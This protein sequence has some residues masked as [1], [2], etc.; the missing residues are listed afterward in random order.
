MARIKFDG[1]DLE[2]QTDSSVLSTLLKKGYEIP[3]SCQAGVCQ[4]CL[5]QATEGKVPELAQKGLKDSLKAQNY[6]LACSCHPQEDLSV[7]LPSAESTQIPAVVTQLEPLG[8]DIM[9]LKLKPEKHFEYRAGQHVTLWR[10]QHIG[11]SYSLASIPEL[12][13]ELIFHIKHVANGQFSSWVFKQ[14]AVGDKINIQGP[15]GDC[16]YTPGDDKQDILL[17]GT[18]TGL[19]PLYGIVRDALRNGIKG[20]IH[21]F[22]GALDVS[23]LYLRKEL[24]A[25][26]ANH[27]NLFYHP[28][29]LNNT[30]PL[31]AGVHQ[32]PIDEI[33]LNIVP[34]PAGRKVFLCG[35]PELVQ[36]LRKTIFLAGSNMNDIYADAFLPSSGGDDNGN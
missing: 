35:A 7:Q 32:G 1:Q 26:A 24:E 3:N 21:L 28:G 33:A 12:D 16:F 9:L 2:V 36:Q 14:L 31:P 11:R 27:E 6:F 18:G 5:M 17:I 30:G 22:H 20:T 10:D 8:K 34:K 13:D 15:A 23:G 29:V 25:L 19:A 4:S